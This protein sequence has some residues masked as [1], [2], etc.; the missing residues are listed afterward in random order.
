MDFLILA[1]NKLGKVDKAFFIIIAALILLCV[2]IYFL[3]PVF[4]KEQYAEAR[5]NL[6]EREK[7]FKKN[8]SNK[9]EKK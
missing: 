7:A 2:A 6:Y 5:K 3:I 9:E 8:A 1:L 4:N